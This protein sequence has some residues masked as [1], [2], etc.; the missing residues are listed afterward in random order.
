M[1]IL[2]LELLLAASAFAATLVFSLVPL[3]CV[4]CCGGGG[5]PRRPRSPCLG[6]LSCVAGGVFVAMS[7]LGLLP[8]ARAKF[9]AVLRESPR[10]RTEFPAAECVV[11]LGFFLLLTLERLSALCAGG[12]AAKG[13]R[14]AGDMELQSSS[15]PDAARQL[16]DADELEG[17]GEHDVLYELHPAHG[18]PAGGKARNGAPG[19]MGA[20]G[21]G[22]CSHHQ[23][24]ML[25]G[26]GQPKMGFATLV[27]ALSIHA[28]FEGLALGLQHDTDKALRLFI[29]IMLHECLCALA[30]GVN[31]AKRRP[32]VCGALCYASVF[33]AALPAGI[34]VGIAL[35]QT[36]GLVGN[37]V[38]GT[39]Q[40]L[41]AGLFIHVTF[42]EIVP[43]E[44]GGAK[45][46]DGLLK[47]L[48]LFIGFLF[49]AA[50]NL[51]QDVQRFFFL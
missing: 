46:A 28:V 35:G 9:A 37:A 13:R 39:L 3:L 26:A 48:F 23:H 19:S 11:V 45:G 43:A 51:A 21:G 40:A 41:A 6:Y 8:A 5:R 2:A 49:V 7:F 24:M 38:S 32:T 47:V 33:C 34:G 30:M 50:V 22:G 27:L 10:V 1:D 20:E 29:A 14:S 36:P 17:S 25:P 16:L 4:R 18:N 44:L 31:L 12:R 42:V 15:D